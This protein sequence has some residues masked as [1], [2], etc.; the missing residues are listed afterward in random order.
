MGA[1]SLTSWKSCL[2]PPFLL[3]LLVLAAAA[4]GVTPLVNRRSGTAVK[5]ALP[6]RRPL[7]EM[8]KE[9]FGPYTFRQA[10]VLAKSM[11]DAL[12]TQEYLDWVFEDTSVKPVSN[13]LR[14]AR[15]F[16]TYYTGGRDP[17]PHVAEECYLGSGYQETKAEDLALEV[18]GLGRSIPV[19]ALTFQRTSIFDRD[20]PTVVYTFHCNGD[21]AARRN[22]VRYRIASLH[23]RYAYYAKIEVSFGRPD[24]RPHNPTREEA[25]AGARKLLNYVLPELLTNHL[26]D[27]EAAAR[28]GPEPTAAAPATGSPTR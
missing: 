26:P 2:R 19:R 5:E 24:S 28:S 7:G 15:L 17:V 8:K 13:P 21:F 27:W 12:G 22:Q 20:E 16:I 10:N 3:A 23:G 14:W 6:L 11:E 9:G 18:P 25:V 1:S 4:F